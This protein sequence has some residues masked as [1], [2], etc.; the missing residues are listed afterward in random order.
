MKTN[1]TVTLHG[2]MGKDAYETFIKHPE[3]GHGEYRIPTL[4]K[5]RGTEKDWTNWNWPP[6][7]VTITI[8]NLLNG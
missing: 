6:V 2:W 5:E 1:D 3:F 8:E 4:V 7:E